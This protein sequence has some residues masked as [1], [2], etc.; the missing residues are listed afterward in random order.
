MII[1]GQFFPQLVGKILWDGR[2]KGE[3]GV[4]NGMGDADF[5]CVKKL[6]GKV[7]SAPIDAVSCD[8][9][10]EV[11][12]M[13][14]NLVGASG[15]WAAFEKGEPVRAGNKPPEG[16]CFARVGA[17]CNGHFPAMDGMARDGGGD[18]TRRHA[19]S[20]PHDGEIVFLCGAIGELAGEGGVGGVGF[21]NEDAAAC[22]LVEAVNDAGTQGMRAGGERRA[23][24]QDGIN[25]GSLPMSGGGV[26]N[27]AGRLVDAE[28]TVV[29]VN[30]VE[31]DCFRECIGRGVGG[32]RRNSFDAVAGFHCGGGGGGGRVDGNRSGCDRPVPAHPAEFR[33][34]GRKPAIEPW[35]GFPG[36]CK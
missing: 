2:F 4:C 28:Q 26:N 3:R 23:M 36:D 9:V 6:A 21:C 33:P 8:G 35:T 7:G 16:F 18:D 22:V 29:F 32:R 24:M 13:N 14:A 1:F 10:A 5:P 15:F 11:F 34:A 31:R 17:V 30:D 25:Q 19:W 12:E 27:K 20:A